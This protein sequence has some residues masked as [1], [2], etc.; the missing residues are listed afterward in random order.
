[1]LGPVGAIWGCC[2]YRGGCDGGVPA[3]VCIHVYIYIHSYI[4]IR[5]QRNIKKIHMCK[6]AS[7][8]D[9]FKGFGSRLWISERVEIE[10][11]T[12]SEDSLQVLRFEVCGGQNPIV[13][14][15]SLQ[16]RI[17]SC[18]KPKHTYF[19]CSGDV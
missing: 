18:D 14:R 11:F 16:H 2:S 15:I 4:C 1:M 7:V 9:L 13:K 19:K 5:M 10:S 12:E 6:Y 3:I 8:L 17:Q